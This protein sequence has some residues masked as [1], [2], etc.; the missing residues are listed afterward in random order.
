MLLTVTFVCILCKLNK[1]EKEIRVLET[2]SRIMEVE[3]GDVVCLERSY[4]NGVQTYTLTFFGPNQV[5]VSPACF[6]IIQNVNDSEKV[7]P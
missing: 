6:T 2:Y 1:E 4:V 5:Q 3:E 7:Y